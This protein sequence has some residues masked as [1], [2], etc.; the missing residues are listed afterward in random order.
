MTQPDDL[1]RRCAR[2][3]DEGLLELAREADTL[4][5]EALATLQSEI[6]PVG[7]SWSVS[8]HRWSSQVPRKPAE[9][10]P[11]RRAVEEP[12]SQ[13]PRKPAEV[14]P[15]RRAVEEPNSIR[16]G[17]SSSRTTLKMASEP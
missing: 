15:Q 2:L 12:V 7:R 9:M 8:R 6:A 3:G 10:K 1:R 14:K 17:F 13:V 4:N 11:Q 5:P 16:R